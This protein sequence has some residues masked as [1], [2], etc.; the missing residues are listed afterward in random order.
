[1]RNYGKQRS[2]EKGTLQRCAT[3]LLAIGDRSGVQVKWQF[4]FELAFELSSFYSRGAVAG[5]RKG[6]M[7]MRIACLRLR[8]DD[9]AGTAR[10]SAGS[11]D[12]TAGTSS[13]LRRPT[14]S[15]NSTVG[16][17][18]APQ[19]TR[20]NHPHDVYSS[21]YVDRPHDVYSSYVATI[22]LLPV[23][24]P[25]YSYDR[26]K[27]PHTCTGKTR[28]S[29]PDSRP[30]AKRRKKERIAAVERADA[31]DLRATTTP[32]HQQKERRVAGELRKEELP[33]DAKRARYL[34]KLLR[35]IESLQERKDNGE[36]LDAA[37]LQKLGRMD[38]VVAELEELF[39][40]DL[41]SSDEED[42]A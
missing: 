29:R 5:R 8:R 21:S 18:H 31:R 22:T 23:E 37:Q 41:G 9:T 34:Q 30:N 26:T 20:P 28:T 14:C 32:K 13:I 1:M 3:S 10:G 42:E 38:E 25:T 33:P 27:M 36:K 6:I 16:I 19:R 35:Q 7:E 2:T 24:Y 17:R 40:V 11:S 15:S 39:G 12:D 4:A